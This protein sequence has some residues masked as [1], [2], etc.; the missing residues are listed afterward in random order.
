MNNRTFSLFAGLFLLAGLVLGLAPQAGGAAAPGEEVDIAALI[1]KAPG[2]SD[3]PEDD[4]LLLYDHTEITLLPDGR[5]ERRYR[6]VIKILT[7]Y[8]VDAVCDPRIGWDSKTQELVVNSLKTY[9]RDGTVVVQTTGMPADHN[10]SQ[11]TPDGLD[12]CPDYMHRQE[13]VVAFLG[14]ELGC[15]VDFDYTVRDRVARKRWVADVELLQG[16]AT[17]LERKFTLRLPAGVEAAWSSENGAPICT[18]EENDRSRIISCAM[19]QV[20]GISTESDGTGAV[21][22]LPCVSFC[23]WL[24]DKGSETSWYSALVA[25][26]EA[27]ATGPDAQGMAAKA[28]DLCKGLR[29]DDDKLRRLHEFARKAVRSV[30]YP[31]LL[32]EEPARTADRIHETAYASQKDHTV[33]LMALCRAEK[34]KCFPVCISDCSFFKAQ[35]AEGLVRGV[36]LS[37]ELPQGRFLVD[38]G[39]PLSRDIALGLHPDRILALTERGHRVMYNMMPVN[40]EVIGTLSIK[41]DRSMEGEMTVHHNGPGNPFLVLRGDEGGRDAFLNGLAGKLMPAGRMVSHKILDLQRNA[42]SYCLKAAAPSLKK[43]ANGS[44][45]LTLI[46]PVDL[47]SEVLPPVFGQPASRRSAPV[48]IPHPVV[49]TARFVVETPEGL[50]LLFQSSGVRM[51][52][53]R[54]SCA[55]SCEKS[56]GKLVIDYMLDLASGVV[57]PDSYAALRKLILEAGHEKHRVFVFDS[58]GNGS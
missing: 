48:Y 51:I 32:T 58:D 55:I 3:L 16:P 21:E 29:N 49:L 46:D 57:H 41:A 52:N 18:L 27:A 12:L 44:V 22:F 30:D 50:D 38:P 36:L 19:S 2:E 7:E 33:L 47:V 26:I 56:D 42:V 6:R 24:D 45:R 34:I 9:Q 11:V 35:T 23:A 13:T 28:A 5:V 54:G 25:E 53:D 17:T 39:A 10:L 1:R 31:A 8:A 14:I 37:V 43:S 40:C 20:P 15:V 4:H